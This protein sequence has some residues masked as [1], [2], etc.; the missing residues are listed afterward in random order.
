MPQLETVGNGGLQAMSRI[1][2]GENLSL[3][4]IEGALPLAVPRY[5]TRASRSNREFLDGRLRTDPTADP[6]LVEF[7]FDAQTSGG[8]LISVPAERAE[9]LAEVARKRG[10]SAACV[11]GSVTERQGGTALV[12][13]P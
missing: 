1:H 13:R 2:S 5:H 3:P 7:A 4:V 8:L 6:A 9:A 12:L 10:A 11:I